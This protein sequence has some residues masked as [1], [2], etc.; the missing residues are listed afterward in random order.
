MLKRL[1]LCA[2]LAASFAAHAAGPSADTQ[3]E[4][5]HLLDYLGNSGCDFYRNGSWH[6]ASEARAHV[7]V[8]YDY[9]L[10][11]GWVK[12]AEDFIARAA[13]K[14]SMSGSTYQV[15]CPGTP[16]V[17]SGTWLSQELARYRA[18]K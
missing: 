3:R 17:A 9:L 18:Q 15:R 8:K 5:A 7:A 10:R 4:I 14:S 16:A 2:C 13:S 6:P 12:T 11:R 1:M